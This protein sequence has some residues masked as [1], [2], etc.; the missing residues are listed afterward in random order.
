MRKAFGRSA[1]LAA[2]VIVLGTIA[3]VMAFVQLADLRATLPAMTV[4]GPLMA[5]QYWYWIRRMGHE[6]T[7]RQ[8]LRAEP[9]GRRALGL[10]R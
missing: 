9:S 1:G 10:G 8:Y 2:V 5:L 6:R 4:L 7:T 3:A